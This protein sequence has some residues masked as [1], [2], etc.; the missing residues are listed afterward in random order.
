MHAA[1]AQAHTF[2]RY[3]YIIHYFYLRA[4]PNCLHTVPAGM[5]L[6]TVVLLLAGNSCTAQ[7]LATA[8]QAAALG[9]LP[10]AERAAA[11]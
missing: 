4:G 10:A 1:A 6:L 5:L 8:S 9:R 11:L 7:R 2:T 3:T